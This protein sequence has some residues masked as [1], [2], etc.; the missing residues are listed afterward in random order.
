[1]KKRG[2]EN[3]FYA[4]Q[5]IS[6]VNFKVIASLKGIRK[7]ILNN[8]YNFDNKKFNL[9]RL[10]SDD[11]YLF[12]IFNQLEEYLEGERKKFTVPLDIK[13]TEFQKKVWYEL[14][15]IPFGKTTS[16]KKIAEQLGNKKALR[17]VGKAASLN[18][19]CIVIPCHRMISSNGEIGGY[20]A[21][22][23]L[24]EKLLELEGSLSLELFE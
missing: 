8:N 11:P 16:Y 17:A 7:I 5:K 15:R 23:K 20:S 3:L 6:G 1:M 18:P 13:G 24:K 12:N 10:R 4:S 19:L 22:L 2:K 14:S 21:G 9:T